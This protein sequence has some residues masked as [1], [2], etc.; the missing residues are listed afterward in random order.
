MNTPGYM[1]HAK[2]VGLRR[3]QL[4]LALEELFPEPC[5][6]TLEIGCG[7]GHWLVDFGQRFP[8]KRC[9]GVDLVSDRIARGAKKV[10]RA[11]VANVGFLKAE[12]MELLDLLPEYVA[13]SEVFVLF[14][15]P[16]PKKR[17]WK[18]RFFSARFLL[19]L[20]KRAG[21]GARCYFRTDHR[22]YFDWAREVVASQSTW[23]SEPTDLWPFE[24]ETVFQMKADSYQSLI[25]SRS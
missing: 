17:H 9:L 21:P 10:E 8:E 3:Q 13:L 16:W 5:S 6:L 11:G 23:R 22:G 24:R 14:P 7:H 19:E 12:A 2:R 25:L 20:A 18:N 1:E 15:D 4:Q